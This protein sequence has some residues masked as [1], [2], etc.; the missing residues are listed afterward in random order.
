MS[1][2]TR[3]GARAAR[4]ESGIEV[5][6]VYRPEDVEKSGGWGSIGEPGEYPFTRGIHPLMYRKRPFTTRQY[7]G[8]GTARET[9]ERFKWLIAGG[10]TGLHFHASHPAGA[11]EWSRVGGLGAAGEGEYEEGCRAVIG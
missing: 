5:Q 1:D 6:P 3:D 7:S 4:L 9:N 8:F 10:Q 11:G 2:K